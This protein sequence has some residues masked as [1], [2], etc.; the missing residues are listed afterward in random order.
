M[1]S[2]RGEV[3]VVDDV[4]LIEE[5]HLI[6]ESVDLLEAM[7]TEHDRDATGRGEVLD[8]GEQFVGAHRVDR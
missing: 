5:D 7:G 6:F 8:Q 3:A 4:T 2:E 1:G